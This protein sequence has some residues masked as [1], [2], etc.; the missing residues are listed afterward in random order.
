MREC[1]I[2]YYLIAEGTSLLCQRVGFNPTFG[3]RL[4]TWLRT[5]P[6]DFLLFGIAFLTLAIITGA[7]WLLTPATTSPLLVLFS[8]LILL[9]PGSQAAV[10]LMN[11]IATNLLPVASL[12]KLD[13][14]QGIP[15]DCVTL[16]A[17]PTLLLNEK[18]VRGL[19]EDLE[20]RYL[21]NHDRNM[22]FALVSD[23]PDSD[24]PGKEDSLLVDL[25]T[26][27][28]EELNERYGEKNEGSFFLLHRHRIYNPREKGWMGGSVSAA[29]CST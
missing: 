22:H 1:H 16:V 3:E 28:I 11:Y 14:A 6:D 20:V 18:Q 5:H 24:Q 27:L 13:F 21:G 9:L 23:L 19:V 8:I 2:G 26:E 29:S 4:R 15:D 7:V 12:P 17:I 25:C 10:Q